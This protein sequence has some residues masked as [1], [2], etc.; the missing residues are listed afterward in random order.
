M[1]N[2]TAAPLSVSYLASQKQVLYLSTNICRSMHWELP[3]MQHPPSQ[4]K[5]PI[6]QVSSSS[7]RDYSLLCADRLQHQTR[8]PIAGFATIFAPKILNITTS[9]PD[10][11]KGT[12]DTSRTGNLV[13]RRQLLVLAI[14][15]S[16]LRV[17]RN[18]VKF[19]TPRHDA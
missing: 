3:K 5:I 9:L 15:G 17:V 4:R 12:K 10:I 7:I 13:R 14:E 16:R 2:S 19:Q 8:E 6:Q 18:L 1:C 11:A